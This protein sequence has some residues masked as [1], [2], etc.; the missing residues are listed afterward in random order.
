MHKLLRWA[1][2]GVLIFLGVS[3]SVVIVVLMVRTDDSL[4]VWSVPGGN[5]N[6]GRRAILVYGCYACHVVTNIPE[7]TGRVGPKLEDIARQIYIGGVLPNSP[8][9]MIAWI[10]NPRR[11]SPQT[12]MPNL[13]V[14]ASDARDITAYLFGKN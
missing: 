14:S 11:F 7:A 13:N 6:Q 12:A 8:D 5:Q 3:L 9:S 4:P 10:E 1:I 2:T